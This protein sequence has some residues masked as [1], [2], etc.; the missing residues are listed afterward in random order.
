MRA[1]APRLLAWLMWAGVLLGC[2]DDPVV[3]GVFRFS[4]AG[5][6]AEQAGTGGQSETVAGSGAAGS[7]AGTSAGSGGVPAIPEECKPADWYFAAQVV[8]QARCRVTPNE[9]SFLIRLE[10]Y[11]ALTPPPGE[12]RPFGS[13]VIEWWQG[14]R[15]D[16][17]DDTIQ[18]CEEW[19]SHISQSYLAEQE[20]LRKCM[21]ESMP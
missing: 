21:S 6:P 10:F 7:G 1:A 9:I 19:C 2:N 15:I 16:S 4:A 17:P 3:A 20:R 5:A 11:L 18:V 13:C 8:D 12:T 14:M